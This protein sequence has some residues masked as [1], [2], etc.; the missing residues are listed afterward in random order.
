MSQRAGS[1]LLTVVIMLVTLGLVMLVSTG[2]WSEDA[3]IDLY[4]DVK[5]QFQWLCVGTGACIFFALVDYHVWEKWAAWIFGIACLLLLCCFVPGVGMRLNG[6][7]RWVR[8]GVAALSFQPSELA[9][10]ATIFLVAKWYGSIETECRTWWNGFL[11]PLGMIVLPVLLISAEPDIG[12]AAVLGS[13]GLAIMFAAGARLRGVGSVLL[14][15]ALAIAAAVRFIPNRLERFTA[16]LHLD[17]VEYQQGLGLQQY[18]A[19]LAFG[20]GGIGGAG[21]GNGAQKTVLPYAHTDFIFPMIGEELGL[22]ATL[23]VVFCFVVLLVTGLLISLQAPDRFGKLT[24][25]GLVT[26]LGLQAALNIAV[27]TACLPNKGLP[28]PFISYGG[29]NLACCLA[30]VGLLLNIH[31][32]GRHSAPALAGQ[33]S[34]ARVMNRA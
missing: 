19:L 34:G 11:R 12:T 13:V 33:A 26:M 4:F 18:R 16:F 31:R 9:K 3:K 22:W 20:T 28:L 24:G 1:I 5:R 32:Q 6:A 10:L 25:I 15:G 14:M 7:A 17:K 30:A 2:A 21:L 8:A 29:S 23:L 27:T